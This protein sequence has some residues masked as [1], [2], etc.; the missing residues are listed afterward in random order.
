VSG[1][2]IDVSVPLRNGMVHWPGDLP[3]ERLE[4][5]RIADGDV[6]NL[7]TIGASAHIG[8]HVDSPRHFIEGALSIEAMPI[9]AM[10]GPARVIGIRDSETIRPEELEPYRIARGERVLFRTVNSRRCWNTDVFQTDFVAISPEAAS[11]LA[12][13]GVR[14]VGVDYLSVGPFEKGGP[15]THL[16]LLGAGVWVIEGLNLEQVEP[17]DY[18]LVCLPLRIV[19]SDGAPAR[20][21][22]RKV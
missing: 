18:E 10:M 13:R 20:A 21:L 3:F 14:T 9:E 22:V 2:W 11:Y 19:G 5:L 12:T 16:A 8:T 4:T 15:E 6:C 7:S 1:E 17:G